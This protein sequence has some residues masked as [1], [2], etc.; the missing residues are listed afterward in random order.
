MSRPPNLYEDGTGG[1]GPT[2]RPR[3]ATDGAEEDR[4]E[5]TEAIPGAG[6]CPECDAIVAPPELTCPADGTLLVAVS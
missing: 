4:T 1:V 6:R 2:P 3:T 5:L